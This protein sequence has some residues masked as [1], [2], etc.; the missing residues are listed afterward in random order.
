[1]DHILDGVTTEG[2]GISLARAPA[3]TQ[4]DALTRATVR[5][6]LT[7]T[8]L[9]LEVLHLVLLLE[10]SATPGATTLRLDRSH[11]LH[12]ASLAVLFVFLTRLEL[13][14]LVKRA[15]AFVLPPDHRDVFRSE[16]RAHHRGLITGDI[17]LD[18]DRYLLRW[19]ERRM[20]RHA[21]SD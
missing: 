3:V 17:P 12:D 8:T 9:N 16:L 18:A 20:D 1:M 11:D 2:L 7:S 10:L 21:L 6:H 19:V 5:L 13:L 15:H 4:R 14:T